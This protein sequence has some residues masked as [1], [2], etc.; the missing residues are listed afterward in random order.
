MTCKDL[1]QK[2]QIQNA[3]HNGIF[4]PSPTTCNCCQ[5]CLENISKYLKELLPI[6]VKM[7]K[8]DC[9]YKYVKKNNLKLKQLHLGSINKNKVSSVY[10]M[11]Q[12]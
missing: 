1:P 3:T 5:Y 12:D 7:K 2:C 8:A 11:C 6:V 9:I 10:R 4:L